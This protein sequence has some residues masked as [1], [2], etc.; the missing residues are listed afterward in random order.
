MIT[1]IL[2]SC[3][4]NH[5]KYRLT[6]TGKG[7]DTMGIILQN[8]IDHTSRS[9]EELSPVIQS[10]GKVVFEG[11]LKA[12]CFSKLK[13][14]EIVT[15]NF[16][17]SNTSV[18]ITINPETAE[19]IEIEGGYQQEMKE[20][21]DHLMQTE[22]KEK[23]YKALR[24]EERGSDSYNRILDSVRVLGADDDKIQA[25]F[26]EEH[27]DAMMS[28]YALWS[29]YGDIGELEAIRLFNLIDT[30]LRR[31]AHYVFIEKTIRAWERTPVGSE[32]PDLV[33]NDVT[34]TPLRLSDLRGKYLLID[35]WASWCAPC[36]AANPEMV[37]LYHKYSS[38]GIE[39]LGVS[40]DKDADAWEKAIS[41]DKLEWKHVSDLKYWDNEISRYFGINSIPATLLVDPEGK[42]IAKKLHGEELAAKLAEL[43]GY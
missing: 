6:V 11:S 1:L 21:Y 27:P 13:I 16:V 41:D 4:G 29:L 40:L 33:Q 35:F 32:I 23:L 43:F 14:G 3:S 31:Q 20:E 5:D 38:G 37:E 17:L 22:A 9:P 39:F 34:G 2:V 7:I 12:P 8:R 30:A 36:R 26:I 19:I 25:R 18:K 42:I 24:A 15:P 28:P 10:K